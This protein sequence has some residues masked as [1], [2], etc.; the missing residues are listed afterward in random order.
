MTFNF[1]FATWPLDKLLVI[2]KG[3]TVVTHCAWTNTTTRDLTF[4]D[5]MCVVFG[6]Y[7]PGDGPQVSCVD[8]NWMV[9]RHNRA[10][11]RFCSRTQ[12]AVAL[13]ALR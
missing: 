5:E 4:P 13:A 6:F 12:E 3:D 8:N 1:P 2:K 9:A 11:A 7:I 10:C